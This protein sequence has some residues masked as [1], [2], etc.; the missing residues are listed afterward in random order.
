MISNGTSVNSNG[1]NN[2]TGPET[3]NG[4]I[5]KVSNG[6]T[7]A[8]SNGSVSEAARWLT[9]VRAKI[10]QIDV[11]RAKAAE[12]SF[13]RE[14]AAAAEKE[15]VDE[16]IRR[17]YRYG[18]GHVPRDEGFDKGKVK[19]VV[20]SKS[21]SRLEEEEERWRVPK[22]PPLKVEGRS[23]SMMMNDYSVHARF[24]VSLPSGLGSV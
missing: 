4:A 1:H 11:E 9:R 8:K 19:G 10:A 16:K 18:P 7:P 13:A 17:R 20:S 2:G 23:P 6:R 22:P 15:K 21:G 3:F 24:Q 12:Q 5:A 14:K